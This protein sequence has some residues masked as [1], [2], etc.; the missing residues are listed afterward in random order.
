MVF[1]LF[2]FWLAQPGFRS[3]AFDVQQRRPYTEWTSRLESE[4]GSH[5]SVAQWQSIRLLTEWLVGS[6]PT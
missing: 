3:V 6:S 4:A 2:R 5:S 1:A